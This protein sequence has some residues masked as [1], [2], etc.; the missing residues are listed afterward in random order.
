MSVNCLSYFDSNQIRGDPK[1]TGVSGV[2]T[3]A[4]QSIPAVNVYGESNATPLL[5]PPLPRNY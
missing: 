1:I 5:N 3:R 4:S 2:I